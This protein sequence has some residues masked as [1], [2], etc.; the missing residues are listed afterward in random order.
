MHVVRRRMGTE[1]CVP[2]S[3][4]TGLSIPL[5]RHDQMLCQYLTPLLPN[6]FL[7]LSSVFT[8]GI[9]FDLLVAPSPLN[10]FAPSRQCC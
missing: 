8:Y 4:M 10:C 5:E 7:S 9:S 3:A 2:I 1:S 6:Q